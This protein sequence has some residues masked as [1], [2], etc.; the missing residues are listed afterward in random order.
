MVTC[1]IIVG[2]TYLRFYQPRGKG[3]HGDMNDTFEAATLFPPVVRPII[4]LVSAALF[5]VA[6]SIGLCKLP[7]RT[8]D[9]GGPS[10]ITISLPGSDP[11]DAERRRKKALRALNERLERQKSPEDHID[12]DDD[13]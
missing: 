1:G 3:V 4:S 2:W 9:V 8:Y 10:S 6:V 11:A 7:V 5:K 13:K 12:E